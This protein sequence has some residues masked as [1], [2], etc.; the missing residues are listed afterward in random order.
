MLVGLILLNLTLN[1]SRSL[2]EGLWADRDI[3]VSYTIVFFF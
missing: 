1:L 3:T 2:K